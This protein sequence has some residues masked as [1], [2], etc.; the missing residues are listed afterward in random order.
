M[1]K[2]QQQE[3]DLM[4]L[5]GRIKDFYHSLLAAFYRMAQFVF[6][7]WIILV[8]LVVGGYFL[9]MLWQSVVGKKKDAVIL[10]QNNFGSTNYVYNA[11]E[12][13]NIKSGQYDMSFLKQNGF[14]GTEP[15]IVEVVIEPIVSLKDLLDQSEP[16]DRNIDFYM[17]EISVEDDVMESQVF[18]PQYRYHKRP[19]LDANCIWRP[20]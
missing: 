9:G 17:T 15:E 7:Y 18:Y 11:I 12:L 6:K 14:D 4:F 20:E 8:V 13:L 5:L 19:L 3:V 10:V 1:A 16:N 2:E